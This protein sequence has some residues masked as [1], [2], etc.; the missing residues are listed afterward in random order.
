MMDFGPSSTQD[1]VPG[2]VTDSGV[3]TLVS[4]TTYRSAE[5]GGCVVRADCASPATFAGWLDESATSDFPRDACVASDHPEAPTADAV[6]TEAA[7]RSVR[8]ISET[9]EGL[10]LVF[11]PL[12]L[13]SGKMLVLL[14]KGEVQVPI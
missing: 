1:V 12:S 8:S 13:A 7:T 14:K 4:G 2:V 10:M 5:G 3:T 6:A 9:T 11:V